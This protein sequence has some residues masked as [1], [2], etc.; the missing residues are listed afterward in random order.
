MFENQTENLPS[1]SSSVW[2]PPATI[3]KICDWQITKNKNSNSYVVELSGV[4]DS[5]TTLTE[6]TL[7]KNKKN[8]TIYFKNLKFWLSEIK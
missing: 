6:V 8:I 4:S 1:I 3:I 7:I 5:S 2:R